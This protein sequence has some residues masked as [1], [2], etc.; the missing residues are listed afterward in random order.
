MGVLLAINMA[1]ANFIYLYYSP[2]V[3]GLHILKLKK[4]NYLEQHLVDNKVAKL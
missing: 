3:N 2:I 1:V 4:T